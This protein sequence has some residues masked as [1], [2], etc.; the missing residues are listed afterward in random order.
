MMRGMCC[1]LVMTPPAFDHLTRFPGRLGEVTTWGGTGYGAGVDISEDGRWLLA[2][3]AGEASVRTFDLQTGN[4]SRT[5]LGAFGYGGWTDGVALGKAR[6]LISGSYNTFVYD[7][8]SETGVLGLT[9]VRAGDGG[10][11][12][13]SADRTVGLFAQYTSGAVLVDLN[14]A[15]LSYTT[16]EADSYLP[17]V[18]NHDGTLFAC[19]R[20]SAVLVVERATGITHTLPNI[21]MSL[22]FDPMRDVLY[23]VNG[24]TGELLGYDTNTWQQVY[25]RNIGILDKVGIDSPVNRSAL[26]GNGEF[27]FSVTATEL[28]VVPLTLSAYVNESGGTVFEGAS[29]NLTAGADWAPGQTISRYEWDLDYDGTK[30]DV[31]ATGQTPGV[32]A[33]AVSS[34]VTRTVGLRV[35]ADDG[36]VSN[37]ATTQLTIKNWLPSVTVSGPTQVTEGG[38]AAFVGSLSNALDGQSVTYE[39]DWSYDGQ[40][41]DANATGANA[42]FV[43]PAVTADLVRTVVLRGRAADGQY[44]PVLTK[45]LTITAWRPTISAGNSYVLGEGQA[46]TLSGSVTSSAL[47]GYT[48]EWDLNYDGK[49]FDVDATGQKPVF[50][51]GTLR[52][53]TTRT[54]AMRLKAAG[55]VYSEVAT[56]TLTVVNAAPTATISSV[57]QVTLGA[58]GWVTLSDIKDSPADLAAGLRYNFDLNGDGVNEVKNSTSPTCTVPSAYL[59]T[60]GFHTIRARVR[61]QWNSVREYSTQILVNV[62]QDWFPM[63]AGVDYYYVGTE[64][65][66]KKTTSVN[67]GFQQWNGRD[68]FIMHQVESTH[69]TTLV[70]SFY[71]RNGT[72]LSLIGEHDYH[73]ASAAADYDFGGGVLWWDFGQSRA[74]SGVPFTASAD[75][76]GVTVAGGGTQDM[77]VTV[78]GVQPLTLANGLCFPEALLVKQHAVVSGHLEASTGKSRDSVTT[79]DDTAYFVRGLGMVYEWYRSQ[80]SDGTSST[81]EQL[82]DSVPGWATFTNV[83]GGILSVYGSDSSDHISFQVSGASLVVYRN[84]VPNKVSMAGLTGVYVGGYA[85]AD[86]IDASALSIPV[87][88][89]G[90]NGKDTIT[91]ASGKDVINGNGGDD[92]V[93]GGGGD[94]VIHGGAGNDVLRGNAGNDSL[95]GDAGLDTIQGGAGADWIDV[96]DSSSGDQVDGGA[97]SDTAIIDAGDAVTNVEMSLSSA[98]ATPKI[99]SIKK[100]AGKV[101]LQWT[102]VGQT[103]TYQVRRST[104]GVH[105]ALLGTLAGNVLNCVDGSVL[106]GQTYWYQVKSANALGTSTWSTSGKIVA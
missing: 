64:D 24:R 98:P 8:D 16:W 9:P 18:L 23:G 53:G 106:A 1:T 63:V 89:N 28:A 88:I 55:N 62:P 36:S 27:L 21:T 41:F 59:A 102:A 68:A 79:V 83:S 25:S 100:A 69:E 67:T 105:F 80:D 17:A 45:A 34:D 29:I 5:S 84:G 40:T 72:T 93:N 70:D 87:T 15:S 52:S 10:R 26:S 57:E 48:Y 73:D 65:G 49:S 77:Q 7:F 37:V 47:S 13:R 54:I 86:V 101:T 2:A 42:S 30:F 97:D 66:G 94:D 19:Q 14:S 75:V 103:Q 92:V 46:T 43:A 22:A 44:G 35:V 90:G 99:S 20:D 74:V 38:N 3:D 4:G 39:W 96:R 51:A 61:D 56:T 6:V 104:D 95:Y 76:H 32:P 82:L 81:S 12:C 50:T 60:A 58:S 91:G 11:V 33:P 78:V 31:D 71:V 85:G